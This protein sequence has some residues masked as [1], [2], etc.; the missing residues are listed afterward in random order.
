MRTSRSRSQLN[1]GD[2]MLE[3]LR[4]HLAHALDARQASEGRTVH[5]PGVGIDVPAAPTER[6]VHHG[7]R[8]ALAALE[9]ANWPVTTAL[10]VGRELLKRQSDHLHGEGEE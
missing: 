3:N 1:K 10:A 6:L 8:A 4:H 5:L 9:V 2:S 7:A